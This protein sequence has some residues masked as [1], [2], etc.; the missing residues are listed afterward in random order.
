MYPQLLKI[1]IGLGIMLVLC[2]A[3]C[4]K[5]SYPQALRFSPHDI[6]LTGSSSEN[7]YA[8]HRLWADFSGPNGKSLQ[9]EGFWNGGR[10]WTMRVALPDTGLWKYVTHSTDPL[11]DSSSGTIQCIESSGHLSRFQDRI[12]AYGDQGREG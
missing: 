5:A 11:L 7:P 3:D 1:G 2:C 9:A 4:K 12:A 6:S 8:I 10:Q